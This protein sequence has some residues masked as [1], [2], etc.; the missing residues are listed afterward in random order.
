MKINKV[1]L[2]SPIYAKCSEDDDP[3]RND[4]Q[5]IIIKNI[6]V[7]LTLL[8]LFYS[9]EMHLVTCPSHICWDYKQWL[10]AENRNRN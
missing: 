8:K 6:S 10:E 3:Q 9:K 7:I 1:L 5:I 4:V 2:F